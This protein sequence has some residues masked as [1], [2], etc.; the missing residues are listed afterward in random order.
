MRTRAFWWLLAL[1][2]GI[3]L[4]AALAPIPRALAAESPLDLI[5]RGRWREAKAILE[6]RVAANASDAEA[7][8]LLSRVRL[9]YDDNQGALQLAEK[10]VALDDADA[11]FHEQL[12]MVLGDKAQDAGPLSQMRLAGKFKKEADRAVALDP[13]RF[14]AQQALLSFYVK[15]PGI[16]GGS[17]EKAR[18]KAEE[19]LALDPVEGQLAHARLAM[20]LKDSTA[21]L[22]RYRKAVAADPESY[23]AR[24]ALASALAQRPANLAEAEQHALEARRI[25]SGR[26]GSWALLAGIYAHNR[27][28]PELDALLAEARSA[29]PGN[30]SAEYSAAR[31]MVVTR[32]DPARAERL[33]RDYLTVEPEPESPGRAAAHWRLALA[34]EQQDRGRE[35]VAELESAVRLDPDFEPAKKDLKRM[36]KQ[37]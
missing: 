19:I 15:A 7:A 1:A 29:V 4:L 8:W 20:E 3:G 33:L 18:A 12:A 11:R 26:I 21:A 37:S 31:T 25:D 35:A 22:D 34:L 5:E 10:A 24:I 17:K 9:A 16:A 2:T 36:R 27:R 14:R 23:E 30:R 28:W 13:R 32:S 6:P